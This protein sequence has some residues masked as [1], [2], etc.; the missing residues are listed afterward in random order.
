MAHG[1]QSRLDSG[2]GFQVEVLKT[3]CGVASSLGRGCF[4]LFVQ[5]TGDFGERGHATQR[6]TK[7]F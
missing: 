5:W 1:R 6:D 7:A 2:L 3:V 4:L